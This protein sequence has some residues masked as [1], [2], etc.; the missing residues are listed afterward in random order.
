VTH[1]A[2]DRSWDKDRAAAR[3]IRIILTHTNDEV[4]NLTISPRRLREAGALGERS[5]Q[6]GG[7][8]ATSPSDRV[9]FLKN[10]RG[11]GLRRF[12]GVVEA[13]DERHMAVQLDA[14]RSVG[15]RP[16]RLRP[17]RSWLSP[18]PFLRPKA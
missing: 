18:P 16:E 5:N 7:D 15:V 11:L 10:D 8:R 9:M 14:G 17:P 13:V 4:M 3:Q 6:I 12:L 1:V 2:I